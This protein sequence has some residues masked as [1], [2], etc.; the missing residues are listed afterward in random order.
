MAKSKKSIVAQCERDFPQ[1]TDEFKNVLSDMYDLFA[2]KQ[3]DYGPGNIAMGTMLET[4]DEIRMSLIGIIVRM[5]DK[6]NRLINLVVKKNKEP[7]NESVV[8]SF[9]DIGNYSVMAKILL[10]KKWGK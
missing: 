1:S 9:I 10:E 4:E 3:N 8:D 7:E 6:I 5:N 2:R